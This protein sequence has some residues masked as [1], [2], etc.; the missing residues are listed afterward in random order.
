M[1]PKLA[2]SA[3]GET[4]LR[5]SRTISSFIW[6]AVLGLMHPRVWLALLNASAQGWLIINLPSTKTPRFLSTAM[7]S[8]LVSQPVFT[9]RI[10][11]SQ[12]GWMDGC[13]ESGICS[14]NFVKLIR[15]L[16]GPAL[17]YKGFSVR[18]LY[19]KEASAP[20]NLISSANL[21]GV[22]LTPFD[23]CVQIISENTKENWP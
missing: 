10:T 7:T 4:A 3:Q 16:P 11:P 9:S 8:N 23:S 5:Q 1:V 6:L 15:A 13:P 22:P 17:I 19:L 21:L 12:V 14:L 18:P 20:S 2:L